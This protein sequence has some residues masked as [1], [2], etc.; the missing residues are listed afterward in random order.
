MITY[1][2]QD[3]GLFGSLGDRKHRVNQYH[4][5]KKGRYAQKLG[6]SPGKQKQFEHNPI[7]PL[8]QLSHEPWQLYHVPRRTLNHFTPSLKSHSKSTYV[9]LLRLPRKA[10]SSCQTYSN[11]TYSILKVT[12]FLT[13]QMNPLK[14]V[15][16]AT[17]EYRLINKTL[18][19]VMSPN[20]S[21]PSPR[22]TSIRFVPI[23]HF[24]IQRP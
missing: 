11:K 12:A 16:F 1:L 4:R 20:D 21:M 9:F 6:E 24:S 8:V 10:F 19:I 2:R 22:A 18:W 23:L 14:K 3:W 7:R 5:K 13:N 15:K 17:V